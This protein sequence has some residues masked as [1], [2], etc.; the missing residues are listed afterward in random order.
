[1]PLEIAIIYKPSNKE[2]LQSNDTWKSIKKV[3]E[4]RHLLEISH[5]NH[6]KSIELLSELLIKEKIKHQ[7]YKR[8]K[9]FSDINNNNDLWISLGGDGTFLHCSHK[10]KK[11]PIL[12]INSSPQTSVGHYCKFSLFSQ[13]R[14]FIDHLYQIEQNRVQPQKLDRLVL[15]LGGKKL[16]V[17]ILNDILISEKNP[18]SI[19][20]YLLCLNKIKQ[21]HKS[22]GIW[23]ST[24]NGSSAAFKS[25]GGKPFKGHNSLKK[26]QFAFRVRELYSCSEK[27]AI[28]E[29]ILSEKDEFQIISG[30]VT[31]SIFIDGFKNHFAFSPGNRLRISFHP[32]PLLAYL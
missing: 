30:M 6:T 26:R 3:D 23:I 14:S 5:E 2:K 24:A 22:S 17:P 11:V 7:F 8:D 25:A 21:W 20:F 10:F 9:D 18:A 31:G 28:T 12:G 15:S 27:K 16:S 32:L 13:K 1:M 19:S 29:K 4:F